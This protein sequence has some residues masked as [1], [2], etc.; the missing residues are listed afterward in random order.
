M[1]LWKALSVIKGYGDCPRAK[2]KNLDTPAISGRARHGGNG[3]FGTA[4]RSGYPDPGS[5]VSAGASPG[6]HHALGSRRG[7]GPGLP[8][9]PS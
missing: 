6:S 1:G 8:L 4:S 7:A 2:V 5:S 3:R 9:G